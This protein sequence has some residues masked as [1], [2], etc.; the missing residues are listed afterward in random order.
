MLKVF[1]C[2]DVCLLFI[3]EAHEWQYFVTFITK[4]TVTFAMLFAVCTR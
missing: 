4:K 3:G 2:G 1:I